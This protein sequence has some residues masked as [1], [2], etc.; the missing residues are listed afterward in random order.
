VRSCLKVESAIVA[1]L[2]VCIFLSFYFALLSFQA[3]DDALKKQLVTLAAYTLIS[4][5][6]ILSILIVHVG[7]KKA[8][9]TVDDQLRTSEQ[10]SNYEEV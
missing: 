8:F 5:I 10:S 9:S 1:V 3:M 4:G 2:A 6:I 7:I